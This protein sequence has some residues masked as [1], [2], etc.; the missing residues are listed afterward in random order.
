MGKLSQ[1]R[2]RFFQSVNAVCAATHAVGSGLAWEKTQG[3]AADPDPKRLAF[4]AELSAGDA[5]GEISMLR[6]LSSLLSGK[7][8]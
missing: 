3:R 5:L 2:E 1:W 6:A 7:R 4:I 8:V